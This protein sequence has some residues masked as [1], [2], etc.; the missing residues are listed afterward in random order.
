[1][2]VIARPRLAT[3]GFAGTMALEAPGVD[4]LAARPAAPAGFTPSGGAFGAY[5]RTL[6]RNGLAEGDGDGVRAGAN[7][8]R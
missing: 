5:L 8:F 7:L 4:L 1:M 2:G 3:T 6:R